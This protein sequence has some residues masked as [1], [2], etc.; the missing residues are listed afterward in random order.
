M[1]DYIKIPS[2]ITIPLALMG[3]VVLAIGMTFGIGWVA[4]KISN[5]Y[6]YQ[7]T[8][9]TDLKQYKKLVAEIPNQ[10]DLNATAYDSATDII[11]VTYNFIGKEKD[12]TLY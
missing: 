2:Y 9:V 11:L 4:Y 1:K 12:A 6:Q 8:I 10:K 3:V 5:D 7:G